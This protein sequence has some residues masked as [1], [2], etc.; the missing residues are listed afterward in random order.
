M[1]EPDIQHRWAAYLRN[2]S[3]LLNVVALGVVVVYAAWFV[4]PF[5]ASFDQIAAVFCL[6]GLVAVTLAVQTA[7]VLG[8]RGI[9]TAEVALGT[10]VIIFA[11]FTLVGLARYCRKVAER[12][13]TIKD[14]PSHRIHRKR[15]HWA[16]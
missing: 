9:A 12:A 16:D 8:F 3:R 13:E 5:G 7:T 4:R 6:A 11:P 10:F 2:R 1:A 15:A 14:E